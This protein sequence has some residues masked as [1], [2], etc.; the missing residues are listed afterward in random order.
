MNDKICEYATQHAELRQDLKKIREMTFLR[1]TIFL[2]FLLFIEIL[3]KKAV[4][5]IQKIWESVF[6]YKVNQ[7]KRFGICW[8]K[9]YWVLVVCVLSQFSEFFFA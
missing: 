3:P 6:M 7:G 2:K 8:K 1:I 5:H 4:Q 9:P